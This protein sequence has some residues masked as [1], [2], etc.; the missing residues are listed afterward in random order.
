MTKNSIGK[1]KNGFVP[2]RVLQRTAAIMLP[3]YRAIAKNGAFARQWSRAVVATDLIAMGRLL[4]SVSPRTSGLPLGTNGI[5]YFVAFPTGNFRLELAAGVT[6]PPGT[7]QFIFEARAHRAV[8]R[9]I[10]PLYIQL[11][12]NTCFA[13]AFSKAVGREDRRAVNRMVRSL[14]RTPALVSVDV[15]VEQG[16]IALNFKF[17]FSR[18]VY[19]NLLFLQT[20]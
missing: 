1:R 18:F 12:R 7:A 13:A 5:G 20:P 4:K 2:V 3:F 11:A 10:L 8:A 17:P 6:I 15:G 9:A 16:G 14:V 19:R